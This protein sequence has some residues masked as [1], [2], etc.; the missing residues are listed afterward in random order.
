MTLYLWG[1]HHFKYQ[2]YL[3][4]YSVIS[5]NSAHFQTDPF[6]TWNSHCAPMHQ[7]QNSINVNHRRIKWGGGTG[8][9]TC[10]PRSNFYLFPCNFRGKYGTKIGWRPTFRFHMPRLGNS[11]SATDKWSQHSWKEMLK[12]FEIPFFLKN[13]SWV[14]LIWFYLIW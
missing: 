1:V 13:F 5:I 9:E 10:S 12:F 11:G 7:F 8:T 6:N 4:S 3:Q 2:K 14:V